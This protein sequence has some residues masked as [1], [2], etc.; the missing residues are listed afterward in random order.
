MCE[1]Q[2]EPFWN[3]GNFATDVCDGECEHCNHREDIDDGVADDE[4]L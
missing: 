4:N 3:C 2:W 1:G